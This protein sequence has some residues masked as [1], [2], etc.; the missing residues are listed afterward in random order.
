MGVSL[1]GA[2]GEIPALM[3]GISNP[4]LEAGAGDNARQAV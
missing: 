4:L 3:N 1:R 2:N